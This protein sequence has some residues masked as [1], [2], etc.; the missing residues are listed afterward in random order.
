M[1]DEASARVNS[2]P[3][4]P[5]GDGRRRVHGEDLAGVDLAGADLT[6]LTFK[7]VDLS[8]ADLTGAA[9][10]GAHLDRVDLTGAN[11]AGADLR[12][13]SLHRVDLS[14]ADISGAVLSGTELESTTLQR[15]IARDTI[16]TGCTANALD[17]THACLDG[18][19][20]DGAML[21]SSEF[22]GTTLVGTN[23]AGACLEQCR[24][25]DVGFDTCDLSGLRVFRSELA[26]T[27]VANCGAQGA[28]FL[29]TRFDGFGVDGSRF[30]SVF[31]HKCKGLSP[32]EIVALGEAGA[33][34]DKR[35]KGTHDGD[36]V[37][38]R[39]GQA[40][41]G[42]GV[43]PAAVLASASFRN[44][45]LPKAQLRGAKL[46]NAELRGM[47]LSQADLR[48]VDMRSTDL[49]GVD[50]SEADLRGAD[51][52]GAVLDD[53]TLAG[54][55]LDGADLSGAS[56]SAVNLSDASLNGARLTGAQI[57]DGILRNASFVDVDAQGLTTT[58]CDFQDTSWTGCDLRGS[59]HT[60]ALFQRAA[61]KGCDLRGARL[62]RASLAGSESTDTRF[63]GCLL[64][65]CSRLSG[66]ERT[67]MEQ[68][69]AHI[70]LSPQARALREIRQ[71]RKLRF[72]LAGGA[73][74]AALAATVFALV[75]ALWPS[76]LLMTRMAT[77]GEPDTP[78]S[79]SSYVRLGKT[80]QG[81]NPAATERQAR[82][83]LKMDGCYANAGQEEER[84][85]L[86]ERCL[87][88]LP[89]GGPEAFQ[90]TL[91]LSRALTD[92]QDHDRAERVLLALLTQDELGAVPRVETFVALRDVYL[93]QNIDRTGDGRWAA[94]QKD[95]GATLAT[96]SFDPSHDL[97][98]IAGTTVELLLLGEQQLAIQILDHLAGQMDAAELWTVIQRIL[99][100][101]EN[102]ARSTDAEP[103]LAGVRESD[104]LSQH[105]VSPLLTYAYHDVLSTTEQ[106]DA[107]DALLETLVP[108]DDPLDLFLDGVLRARSEL[109]EGKSGRAIRYLD[110][111]QPG[112][113]VPSD[114]V[115][116]AVLLTME[117][118]LAAGDEAAAVEPLVAFLEAESS[119]DVI[120][121][122]LDR[123]SWLCMNEGAKIP[124]EKHLE[125]VQNPVVVAV[126]A[127]G[128]FQIEVLRALAAEGALRLDDPQVVSILRGRDTGIAQEVVNLV[129]ESAESTGETEATMASMLELASGADEEVRLAVGR[130]LVDYSL[131]QQ[132]DPVAAKRYADT[133]GLWALADEDTKAILI[134]ASGLAALETGH[135]DALEGYLA[136]AAA[137]GTSTGRSATRSLSEGYMRW[138]VQQGRH[139]DALTVTRAALA[140]TQE[141]GERVAF[142]EHAVSC[143]VALG[144]TDEVAAELDKLA[145]ESSTCRAAM[146]ASQVYES[147]E[148]GGPDPGAVALACKGKKIPLG[149]RLSAAEYLV[150]MGL[151]SQARELIEGVETLD[152]DHQLQ[153]TLVLARVLEG[154]GRTPEAI[155]LLDASYA[156]AR[157]PMEREMV[158]YGQLA[159]FAS[160]A[161]AEGL[162]SRYRRFATD[163]PEHGR[164][165]VW[166]H[167]AESLLGLGEFDRV[168]DLGEDPAWSETL[169]GSIQIARLRELVEAAD[170]DAALTV[171]EGLDISALEPW[172][173]EEVSWLVA[174]LARNSGDEARALALLGT[175]GEQ[176]PRGSD[177]HV[178]MSLES[179]RL[180]GEFG[181]DEEA[182][183]VVRTL[184]AEDLAPEQLGSLAETVGWVSGRN[185]SAAEIEGLLVQLQEKGLPADKVTTVRLT[186]AEGLSQANKADDA[187]TLLDSLKGKPLSAEQV[188]SRYHVLIGVWGSGEPGS[189]LSKLLEMFPPEPGEAT[190]IAHTTLLSHL[191]WESEDSHAAIDRSLK[192]CAVG[193]LDAWDLQVLS[194]TLCDRGRAADALALL[195]EHASAIGPE[196]KPRL[197]LVRARAKASSGEL[198]AARKDL[199]ELVL[200]DSDPQ[201]ASEAM[202]SLLY[203]VYP[204]DGTTAEAARRQAQQ[205]LERLGPD[206]GEGRQIRAHLVE[207]ERRG[208]RLAQA[209]QQQRQLLKD[210]PAGPSDERAW[211]LLKMARLEIENNG[212]KP[213][214]SA[215]RFVHDALAAAGPEGGCGDDLRPLQIALEV[216]LAHERGRD[217]S[218]A[219]EAR[220][221]GSSGS[222]RPELLERIL[223]ELEGFGLSSLVG[224]LRDASAPHP[225]PE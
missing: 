164:F 133:L 144:R 174:E 24:V 160:T 63:A 117:A 193:H 195:A 25:A 222:E 81:R 79:C 122:T 5:F 57:E 175:L 203:L 114:L 33:K 73:V 27:T 9:L 199:Q 52:R 121:R 26:R 161:D 67:R 179:A 56:L 183:A 147:T 131:Y 180:L 38:E 136:Q 78:Q 62:E 163:H 151:V 54:A 216:A 30:D 8:G 134:E 217:A 34:F 36:R 91:S 129:F 94:L 192:Q 201:L 98:P 92:Q 113:S 13:A 17:L 169:S 23:L 139:E 51:L 105:A 159:L 89:R 158:L 3:A 188:R 21:R 154:E 37:G 43:L 185:L 50:L 119:S 191:P 42:E 208:G 171:L 69:G 58:Q 31:L 218:A 45:R 204:Q 102:G 214:D 170:H 130:L 40:E 140:Q 66:E 215:R 189:D 156:A 132:V 88:L 61:W 137:L 225:Q 106:H 146:V 41:M 149:E 153:H 111:L 212:G 104:V 84:L 167:A 168:A 107:A 143:L 2:K 22:V 194:D 205:C 75:P 60:T 11:L 207:F 124:L 152:S 95:M 72:G 162:L 202:M 68:G 10:V 55:M 59:Q 53:S 6:Q 101:L 16:L 93:N 39:L 190:C 87:E 46:S 123:A 200:D 173:Y 118:H 148:S 112:E 155:E 213:N 224:D 49:V 115:G 166:S 181:R 223:Q 125:G 96:L 157:D 35:E 184:L 86:L 135:E 109:D 165:G 28:A 187:R 209:L 82:L 29:A 210:L 71:S 196:D 4:R 76:S 20:L 44:L 74:L 18:A 177:L 178:S 7:G 182:L 221:Q 77:A 48:D 103:F 120:Q 127:D 19:R 100:S 97:E 128:G 70:V 99:D 14:D 126:L 206:S 47:N 172:R 15:T 186:A 80:L 1:D 176:A 12:G 141:K 83:L 65:R 32:E 198:A 150:G 110:A 116:I 219:L 211:E 220:L 85:Q 108:A 145:E 90:A 197:A 142:R 138:L 64:N